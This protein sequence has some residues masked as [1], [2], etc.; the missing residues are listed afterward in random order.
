MLK[1]SAPPEI[2]YMSDIPAGKK[3]I[4]FP[5]TERKQ[6]LKAKIKKVSLEIGVEPFKPATQLHHILKSL[7]LLMSVSGELNISR[8]LRRICFS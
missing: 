8:P 3:P 4:Q 6:H 7:V 5:V 2:L 1:R